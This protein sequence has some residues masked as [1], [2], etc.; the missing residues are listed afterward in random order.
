MKKQNIIIYLLLISNF[1][2]AQDLVPFKG[3]KNWYLYDKSK[4]TKIP[5]AY[6]NIIPTKSNIIFVAK[7]NKWGAITHKGI[8]V[9]DFKFDAISLL[10]NGLIKAHNEENIS[11]YTQRGDLINKQPL[12]DAADYKQD[13]TLIIAKNKQKKYGAISIDGKSI[14]PFKYDYAPEHINSK[15]LKVGIEDNMRPLYGLMNSTFEIIIPTKY[16]EIQRRYTGYFLCTLPDQKNELID[17]TGKVIWT[18]DGNVSIIHK[19]FF[20][21]NKEEKNGVF[22]RKTGKTVWTENS[23]FIHTNLNVVIFRNDDD[24]LDCYYTING[25]KILFDESMDESSDSK[26]K[27]PFDQYAFEV[28]QTSSNYVKFYKANEEAHEQTCLGFYDV[29]NNTLIKYQCPMVYS[30]SDEIAV[31]GKVVTAEN[32]KQQQK[33]GI[34][35]IKTLDTIVPIKNNE[36]RVLKY[37]FAVKENLTWKL[38]NNK[39]QQTNKFEYIDFSSHDRVM[40]DNKNNRLHFV[41]RRDGKYKNGRDIFLC[42]FVNDSCIEIIP[43]KY[44]QISLIKNRYDALPP[45]YLYSASI[46]SESDYN[47]GLTA[48]FNE[49]FKPLTFFDYTAIHSYWNGYLICNLFQKFEGESFNSAG[50]MDIY[51]NE[52]IKPQYQEIKDISSQGFIAAKNGRMCFLNKLGKEIIPLKFERI[53]FLNDTLLKVTLLFDHDGIYDVTGKEY[54]KPQA[55]KII[56]PSYLDGTLIKV[57]GKSKN[58][59]NITEIFYVDFNGKQYRD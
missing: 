22:F 56:D 31:I 30:W 26:N 27:K 6:Q 15:Y 33:Y 34:I 3:T 57:E 2:W 40:F 25:D 17:S 19:F 18:G 55:I 50:I 38:Y 35:N 42:G 52:I 59:P 1:V 58:D 16:R 10:K 41:K 44:L 12:L 9:L 53:H 32:G 51:G 4:Q 36:I 45:I 49:N 37:G 39:A 13:S 7:N 43:S 29:K 24:K 48:L 21:L 14:M 20:L 8:T 23:C 46:P 28:N 11:L 54:F 47:Y 5:E